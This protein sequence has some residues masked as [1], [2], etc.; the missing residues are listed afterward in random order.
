MENILYLT[1]QIINELEHIK[2]TFTK[3][4]KYKKS[5]LRRFKNEIEY[6]KD[7]AD[8]LMHDAEYILGLM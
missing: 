8:D 1:G 6:I 7:F 4:N 5:D 2:R 3:T